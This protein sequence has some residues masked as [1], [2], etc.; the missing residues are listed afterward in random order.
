MLDDVDNVIKTISGIT[1]SVSGALVAGDWLSLL[2]EHAAAFGV[3]LGM[4]TFITNL[5]FNYLGYRAVMSGKGERRR[6]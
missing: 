4:A 3:I 1:Y 5:I 2:D 6:R